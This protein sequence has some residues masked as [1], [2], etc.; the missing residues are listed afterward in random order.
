[1]RVLLVEDDEGIRESLTDFIVTK[2]LECVAESTIEGGLTSLK[3]F[4]PNLLILD[5]LLHGKMGTEILLEAKRQD[6][7]PFIVICTALAFTDKIYEEY[8]PDYLLKKPFDIESI[9]Q[10]IT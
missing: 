7:P 8:K 5:L 9:E 1:M 6:K 2:G 10:L 4:K 3:E